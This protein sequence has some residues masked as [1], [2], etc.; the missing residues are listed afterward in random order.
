MSDGE[1]DLALC[2]QLRSWARDLAHNPAEEGH[3]E[4]RRRLSSPERKEI[5]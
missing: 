4:L 3:P 1:L 5:P 2:R